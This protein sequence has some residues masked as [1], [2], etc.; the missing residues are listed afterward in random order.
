MVLPRK[1][2]DLLLSGALLGV[3]VLFLQSGLKEVGSA[4]MNPVDRVVLR[5]SAPIQSAITGAISG[6][7]RGWRRYIYLVDVEQENE[8]LQ[9]ENE[10]LRTM[11]QDA[12]RGV[13]RLHHL[14]KLLGFRASR[15][16]EVVGVR[17]IGRD[18][19]PFARALRVRVDLGDRTLRPGLPVVT[20]DGVVGRVGRVFGSYSDVIL[21]VDPKSAVDVVIQ[22]TG[23]RGILRGIDG[24]NHYTCRIDYL[25]RKEEVKEGDLV[26]TS[27]V[28][29]V[30]PKDLPVGRISRVT[31]RT[32]GLYQ[33]VE[34]TP[35]VDFSSLR[36]MLVILAPPPPPV[37]KVKTTRVA[38]ARGFSP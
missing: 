20:A 34:V 33:E 31:R 32:Y 4:E 6:I 22:R 15:G 18:A 35:A 3:P 37:S 9:S 36:E 23:G 5:V 12:R 25:L 28:A 24:T 1:L 11:L 16:V 29:G 13:G 7:H 14:E 30:F 38:P 27:G 21:A 10:R 8:H 2:R 19:S 26:V 17:A